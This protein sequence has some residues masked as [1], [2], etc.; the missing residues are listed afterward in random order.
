M[1]G[2]T[3][4]EASK[5][6]R[7]EAKKMGLTFKKMNTRLNGAFLWKFVNRKTGEDILTNCTFWGAYE[8]FL[9]GYILTLNQ[10]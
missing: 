2:Y 5:E 1:T 7:A 9:S 3:Q 4:K 8:N 10:N 6:I